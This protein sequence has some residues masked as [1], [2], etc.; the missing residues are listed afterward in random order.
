MIQALRLFDPSLNSGE[1]RPAVYPFYR[2]RASSSD[3]LVPS[4]VGP[5]IPT[6]AAYEGGHIPDTLYG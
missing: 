6:E 3:C 4:G 1:L 2:L 5:L